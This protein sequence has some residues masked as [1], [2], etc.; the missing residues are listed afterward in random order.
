MTSQRMG[1][2]IELRRCESS[3]RTTRKSF[4]GKEIKEGR[5]VEQGKDFK[6]ISKSFFEK[7]KICIRGEEKAGG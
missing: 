5:V 7:P 4:I 3:S 2:E 1:E 6:G